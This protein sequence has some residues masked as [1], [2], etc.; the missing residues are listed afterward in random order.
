MIEVIVVVCCACVTSFGYKLTP[1]WLILLSESFICKFGCCFLR[2]FNP[3]PNF[4][5][6]SFSRYIN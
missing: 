3:D 5:S 1:Y 2:G 4:F 6:F